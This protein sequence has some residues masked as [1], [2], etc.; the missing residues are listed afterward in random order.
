MENKY[1][2]P[3]IEE[4]CVGFEYEYAADTDGYDK[5]YW[6]SD[7][8]TGEDILGFEEDSDLNHIRVKYLDSEDI[9]SC[10]FKIVLDETWI[11]CQLGD[12]DIYL[13]YNTNGGYC[14]ISDLDENLFKGWIKNKS[15]LIKLLKQ[16]EIYEKA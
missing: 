5:V 1:Y 10:G 4:F 13:N 7:I 15:E 2:I 8:T 16:L 9:E 3:S 6:K 11:Y 14:K 12:A